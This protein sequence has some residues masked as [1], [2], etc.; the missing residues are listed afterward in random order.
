MSP[1]RNIA[2]LL[3]GTALLLWPALAPA[4]GLPVVTLE[5]GD[6]GTQSYSLSLQVLLLMTALTLLP[7]L[8]LTMTAFTRVII[9]LGLLRQALRQHG[10]HQKRTAR[11]LGLSYDQLRHLLRKHD[12]GRTEDGAA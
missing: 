10:H 11:A 3:I 6:D 4:A 2:A 1:L 7:A 12:D 5:T 9:V 8:L